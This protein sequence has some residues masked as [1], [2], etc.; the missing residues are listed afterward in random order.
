MKKLAFTACIVLAMIV[1]LGNTQL[2]S[3]NSAEPPSVI[4]IVPNA[5]KDLEITLGPENVKANRIDKTI[6][7]YF[8]FYRHNLMSSNYTL[9]VPTR[10]LTF[11]VSLGSPLDSYNNIFTLN[12]DA[13]TL[14]QGKS[15][16]RSIVLPA[17]R[18][19]LT[20]AIESLVFYLFGYRGKRSWIVFLVTNLITLGFLNISLG[21]NTNPLDNYIILSLI[22]AEFFIFIAEM[23]AFTVLL[24]EHGR[25]RAVSYVI[26]ANF[27]SLVVGGYLITVL[28]I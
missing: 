28:P 2:C 10:G 15:L 20:L 1:P 4:I 5:P 7:S 11:E 25:L 22:F 12:L 3:A 19:T 13:Q 14:T 18:I 24:K 26:V 8:T 6:E 27:L 23:L 17:L 16:S 21:W 9:Y